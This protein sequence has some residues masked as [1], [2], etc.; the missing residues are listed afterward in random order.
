MRRLKWREVGYLKGVIGTITNENKQY[1]NFD[2]IKDTYLLKKPYFEGGVAVENILRFIRVDALWRL[3][4]L[5]HP[6]INKFAVMVSMWF[7]F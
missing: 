1:N 4:Y 5:D 2:G 7:D 3:S 6:K